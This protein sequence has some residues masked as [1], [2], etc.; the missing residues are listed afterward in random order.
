MQP[1][2]DRRASRRPGRWRRVAGEAAWP[3]QAREAAAWLVQARG[4]RPGRW[5]RAG[6]AGVLVEVRGREGAGDGVG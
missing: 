2:R 6:E 4:R 5:R 1:R 3:G